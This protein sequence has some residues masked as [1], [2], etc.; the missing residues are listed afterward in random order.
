MAKFGHPTLLCSSE[1]SRGERQSVE[2]SIRSRLGRS[3]PISNGP[4]ADLFLLH[5][6]ICQLSLSR[7]QSLLNRDRF[8]LEALQ[9]RDTWFPSHSRHDYYRRCW[10]CYPNCFP[11]HLYIYF[12]LFFLLWNYTRILIRIKQNKKLHSNL[13]EWF[14]VTTNETFKEFLIVSTS[15]IQLLLTKIPLI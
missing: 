10:C 9:K 3:L 4:L 12:F 11:L 6:S 5:S 2:T 8:D 13:K 15:S 7:S 1:A 14:R